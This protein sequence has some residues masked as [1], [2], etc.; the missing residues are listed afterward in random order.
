VNGVGT[1]IPSRDIPIHNQAAKGKTP[2]EI[3]PTT[4]TNRS[5]TTT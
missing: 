1:T 5:N 2:T 3:K 4:T